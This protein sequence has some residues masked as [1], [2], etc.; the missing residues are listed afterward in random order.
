MLLQYVTCMLL[1]A[2]CFCSKAI[3]YAYYIYV[4]IRCMLQWV[5]VLS[6]RLKV[7]CGMQQYPQYT[8]ISA[9]HLYYT[10]IENDTAEFLKCNKL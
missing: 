4:H 1:L 7:L 9:E 8:G 10:A 6:V 3:I 2:V 5:Y